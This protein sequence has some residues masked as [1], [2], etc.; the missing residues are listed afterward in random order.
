MDH[1]AGSPWSWHAAEDRM[2]EA[3][4]AAVKRGPIRKQ[5]AVDA[6]QRFPVYAAL[7]ARLAGQGPTSLERI[8]ALRGRVD[9]AI[10]MPYRLALL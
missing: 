5:K 3:G 2:V 1:A 6:L 7:E 8:G 4:W 10:P 9:I